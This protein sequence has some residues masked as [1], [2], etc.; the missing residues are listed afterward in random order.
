MTTYWIVAGACT[1][2]SAKENILSTL[3]GKL[4]T[5]VAQDGSP[6]THFMDNLK[7]ET[8]LKS[9]SFDDLINLT[10]ELQKA[11]SQVEG[12]LRRSERQALELDPNVQL[13]I[14]LG[15]SEVEFERYIR[16]W[17]W[18]STKYD[19]SRFISQNMRFLLQNMTKFDEEARLSLTRY[20]ELKAQNNNIAKKG[21]SLPLTARDLIDTL[22]PDVVKASG[23]ADDDVV[24]TE[25]LT[26]VFVVVPRGEDKEFLSQYEFFADA[27]DNEEASLGTDGVVPM[28]AKKLTAGDKFIEDRD[29]N[30]LYRV[31]LFK[32]SLGK[33]K[34]KSKEAGFS[35]REFTY[36]EAGYSRLIADRERLEDLLATDHKVLLEHSRCLWSDLMVSW[37]HIKAM[38][39]FV[40]SVLRYGSGSGGA[41]S[42]VSFLFAPKMNSA[43]AVRKV[44]RDVI[45]K[46]ETKQ[47]GV[48]TGAAAED[49]DEYFNYVSVSLTPF[50][51]HTVI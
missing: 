29:G 3:S 14:F 4:G 48:E 10:D 9:G 47:P 49:D 33:F 50:T 37:V 45:G 12:M 44:L 24:T 34:K 25:N 32:S 13:K 38:R 26:T 23:G 11:D 35:V 20:N 22:S 42:F 40:E 51:P 30:T 27:D 21:D 8:A 18:D 46:D 36:S 7:P 16:N 6:P 5:R 39:V 19:R 31:V 15:E 17:R 41:Q 1:D 43:A 2:E 28:S